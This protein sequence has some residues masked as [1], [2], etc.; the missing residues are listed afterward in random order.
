MIERFLAITP[1]LTFPPRRT[2]RP[3]QGGR[4]SLAGSLSHKKAPGTATRGIGELPDFGRTHKDVCHWPRTDSEWRGA[5]VPG[6]RGRS[7]GL[8]ISAPPA[9]SHP[10]WLVPQNQE[11]Q[12][13][14]WHSA[15][16]FPLTVAQPLRILTAFPIKP[17]GRPEDV[18]VVNGRPTDGRLGDNLSVNEGIVKGNEWLRIVLP[19]ESN[20]EEGMR[21]SISG[22]LWATLPP[23][24]SRFNFAGHSIRK[25]MSA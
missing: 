9:P 16:G 3:R 22:L 23:G 8:R 14:Q 25:S 11:P 24:Q 6:L 21:A 15:G 19:A 1:I 17:L 10:D 7:P 20:A 5:K 2:F 12:S 4:D 13:G 18:S